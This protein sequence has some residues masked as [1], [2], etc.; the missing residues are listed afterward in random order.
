MWLYPRLAALLLFLLLTAC[1]LP[2][3]KENV[4]AARELIAQQT[5]TEVQWRRE[6]ADDDAARAAARAL[7]RDGISLDE[8]VTLALLLNPEVQLAFEQLEISRSDVVK[9]ATAPNPVA[10][11]GVRDAGGSLAVFYPERTVSVGLLQDVLGLLQLP[12]KRAVARHELDRQ[13]FVTAARIAQLAQG[14]SDAWLEHAAARDIAE[15]RA[16]AATQARRTFDALVL[17]AAN[18]GEYT[19]LD[20]ALERRGLFDVEN[21]AARARLEAESSRIRLGELMGLAGWEEG[22]SVSASLPPLPA[23]DPVSAVLESVALDR[24]PDLQAARKSVDTRL[25]ALSMQRRFRWLGAL[26][27]GA[28]QESA[29]DSTPFFGPN[30]AVEVPLFDQRQAELLAA[31]AELRT[32]LRNVEAARAAARTELR[33]RSAELATARE[34][35]GQ[36]EELVAPAVRR[37][38]AELAERGGEPEPEDLRLRMAVLE[39]AEQRIGLLRDYWR[40][41]SALALAAGE[42]SVGSGL[43]VR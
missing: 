25:R 43:P 18:D 3:S 40:A 11:V 35:L 39:S 21:A 28:F 24:R 12:D 5:R 7:I 37:L 15:L 36:H 34:L 26:E 4:A 14:V 1:S 17:Q 30:A 29:I 8:A 20:L 13:R 16:Q 41:R 10:I 31:D 38:E 9:A 23:A 42:W 19:E 32:A 2:G 22:W 33:L 6:P 27:I